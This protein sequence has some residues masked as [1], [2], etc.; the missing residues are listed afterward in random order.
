MNDYRDIAELHS[1]EGF[2]MIPVNEDKSPMAWL[3]GTEYLYNPITVFDNRYIAPRIA[4]TC[5][6][7]SG[8]LEVFDFDKHQ[9]QDIDS[10]F[11]DFMTHDE[12]IAVVTQGMA[13]IYKT[14]SGGY[15]FMIRSGRHFS[16][17]SVLSRYAD[18]NVMIE[19][20]G[21]GSYVVCHPSEGYTH[22][23]GVEMI[24]LQNI[25]LQLRTSLYTIARTYN[26]YIKPEQGTVKT[27]SW[28][29]FDKSKAWGKFNEEG[30]DEAKQVLKEFGWQ[31]DKIRHKDGVELW[32]RPGKTKGVSATLGQYPNMFYVWSSNAEP[33]EYMKGY[34]YTDIL[35]LLKFN[36]DWNETKQYLIEKYAPEVVPEPEQEINV[37][38]FPVE[39][40]PEAIQ[41][42]ISELNRTL[43]YKMDFLSVSFMFTMATINGNSIK[44]RV[45]NGWTAATTFWFAVVGDSGVM[46]THPVTQMIKPLKQ[47]DNS[48]KDIYDYQMEEYNRLDESQ[49]KK[50]EKPVFKQLLIEDFTLEACHWIHKHNPKG[51][52][53]YKDELVGFINDMNKYR[54]GSDEQFWL[55]SFNNSSYI[56]NRVTKEPLIIN[57]IMVNIIGSIQLSILQQAVKAANGN[58]LI[59]RF[60]YTTSESNIY[61]LSMDDINKEW[62]DWYNS[63][64]VAIE[65]SFVYAEQPT[66]IEMTPEALKLMIEYDTALCNIQTSEDT[67]AGMRNY[68]NKIKTYIPRLALLTCIIDVC[69]D[70]GVY[71]VD[72]RHMKKATMIADYFIS[73]AKF[74]FQEADRLDDINSVKRFLVSKGLSKTDQIREMLAKGFKQV[75][76]AKV[77][78][79]PKSYISKI[80]QDVRK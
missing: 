32:T 59:E 42:Y 64:L 28:G 41:S 51:L 60:L 26:A 76:I 53:L 52:G 61:P 74:I 63:N 36:N 27:G 5:G 67:S 40:F 17:T 47:I 9:G 29:N 23:A 68:L 33:F 38:K 43:N 71:L 37:I 56:V 57:D 20:R 2:N 25:D 50:V 31:L 48:S 62:I 1:F 22:T 14:P 44:L 79:S 30:E 54:K 16:N 3:A 19:V 6:V 73:S 11:N 75:D 70:G 18:G 21:G 66:I 69:F 65:K 39:V 46:K 8:G 78:Q 35:K 34:T 45:K 77:I 4:V 7:A 10:V 24:K 49:K 13:A 55:Q 12:V 80:A 72:D 15:H 58:G